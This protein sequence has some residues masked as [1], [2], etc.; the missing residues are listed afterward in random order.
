MLGN[1]SISEKSS[2]IFFVFQVFHLFHLGGEIVYFS[3]YASESSI[4]HEADLLKTS[5]RL[6]DYSPRDLMKLL[7]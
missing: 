7:M 1:T 5:Q 3:S 4:I 6:T 2:I